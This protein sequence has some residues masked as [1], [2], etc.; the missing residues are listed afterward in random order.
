MAYSS[1]ST[2]VSPDF[3]NAL[4]QFHADIEDSNFDLASVR[5]L[6][7]EI[8]SPVLVV[9]AGQGLIVAELRKHAH[10][11]DGIDFTSEMIRQGRLRRA[12]TLLHADAKS[13][14]FPPATD[15]TIHGRSLSCDKSFHFLLGIWV[16]RQQT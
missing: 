16:I 8:Q 5:R 10:E 9:G 2:G 14:P 3:W 4:A 1:F 11:C 15:R 13:L 6:L 7:P 12:I